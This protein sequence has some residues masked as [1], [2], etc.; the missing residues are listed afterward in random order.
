M[1]FNMFMFNNT[2]HYLKQVYFVLD[3]NDKHYY[4]IFRTCHK[5]FIR[6]LFDNTNIK[7]FYFHKQH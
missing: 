2:G 6:W 5:L 4:I 7:P 3:E 1:Q